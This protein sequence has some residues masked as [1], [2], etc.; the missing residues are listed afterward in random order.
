MRVA[1]LFGGASSEHDVSCKSALGVVEALDPSVYDVTLIG[2]SRDGLWRRVG[3]VDELAG[4]SLGTRLPPLENV[5]VVIPVLHGRFGED[6][7]V[8][9]LLELMG[10]PYVGC[11]VLAS[12]LAMDKGRAGALLAAAGI[13]SIESV[14]VTR[15]SPL[16]EQHALPL[17]VKPNRSG[18]SVGASLATTPAELAEA[19]AYALECDD[20]ALVQPVMDGVE[21]DIAILQLPDGSLR[22]GAPLRVRHDFGFFDYDSKYTVGGAQFE[23][24]AVLPPGVAAHLELLAKRAFEAL[25]CDGLARVDF[26]VA[27]DGS[28]VVNEVNTLPGLSSL[29]QYPT[30]LR[31]TGMDLP[32]VLATLIERALRVR[33]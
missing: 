32:T 5:D 13:P 28:A 25:G 3:S 11:G 14:V 8:Q 31:A 33:R 7:T 4:T 10:L 1:V 19:L 20:S 26:F 9:G 29:S 2:A 12:A 23:V 6:G 17:F 21:I 15:S 22:A 24:P 27:P 16:L 18:S 30:M